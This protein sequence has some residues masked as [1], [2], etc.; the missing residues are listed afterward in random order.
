MTAAC[1]KSKEFGESCIKILFAPLI[2]K[3]REHVAITGV[4]AAHMFSIFGELAQ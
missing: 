4:T 1:K 3:R 2:I